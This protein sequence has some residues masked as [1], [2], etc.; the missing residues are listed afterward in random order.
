MEAAARRESLRAE[1]HKYGAL[2]AEPDLEACCLQ[3][4][5]LAH[6]PASEEF[7]RKAGALKHELLTLVQ[8]RRREE[9]ARVLR[10]VILCAFQLLP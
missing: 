7:M 10:N 3:M 1:L 9:I 4:E 8:V 2:S 6:D 5:K